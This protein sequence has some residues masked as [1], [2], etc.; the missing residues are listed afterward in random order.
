MRTVCILILIIAFYGCE[1][2]Q[3]LTDK[4]SPNVL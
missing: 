2:A 3:Q 1:I 4:E